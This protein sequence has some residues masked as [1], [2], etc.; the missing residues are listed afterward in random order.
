MVD[1]AGFGIKERIVLAIELEPFL[2]PEDLHH[3]C[4]LQL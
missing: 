4:A 3:H 2:I 1:E